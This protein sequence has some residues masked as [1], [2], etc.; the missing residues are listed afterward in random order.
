MR[1]LLLGLAVPLAAAAASAAP[2]GAQSFAADSDGRSFEFRDQ[3]RFDRDFRRDHRRDRDH[4]RRHRRGDTVVI[5]DLGWNDGW[6]LYNNRSWQS[7]SYNDW[8]H[9]RPDRAYPRW[10]HHNR[11]CERVWWSGGGW[12]C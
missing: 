1:T 6:A 9:D 8:W 7:D 11:N 10:V 5:G 12:R 4:R 2:A 3:P